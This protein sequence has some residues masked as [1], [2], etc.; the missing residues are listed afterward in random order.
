VQ[1]LQTPLNI[2]TQLRG[3]GS[4]FEKPSSINFFIGEIAIGQQKREF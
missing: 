1:N 2:L 3:N 4:N